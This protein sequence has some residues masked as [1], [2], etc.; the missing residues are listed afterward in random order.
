MHRAPHGYVGP[1]VIEVSRL[2]DAEVVRG[3]LAGSAAPLV[4][5]VADGL[6]QDVLS[7]GYH[8]LAASAF[9]RV[10]V[11]M[12]GFSAPAWLYAPGA[13]GARQAQA[14]RPAREPA[15]PDLAPTRERR[16]ARQPGRRWRA[17]WAPRRIPGEPARPA[18]AS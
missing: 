13:A 15:L 1:A 12:K 10:Q 11:E 3:A 8:G 18:P 4:V 6:Y 9:V 17:F 5:I 16:P 7:Q 14:G 2:R